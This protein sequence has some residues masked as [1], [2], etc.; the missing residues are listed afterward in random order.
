MLETAT[1]KFPE[2][3]SRRVIVLKESVAEFERYRI[4][5]GEI[6]RRSELG[7]KH[8]RPTLAVHDVYVLDFGK[9]TVSIYDR[10]VVE[11]ALVLN[12]GTE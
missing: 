3:G 7:F 9:L 1:S 12:D 2:P 6:V 5:I 11:A 4:M 10:K 8:V